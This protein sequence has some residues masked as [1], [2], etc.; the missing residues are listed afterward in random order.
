MPEKPLLLAA[1]DQR[2]GDAVHAR[3]PED[4]RQGTVRCTF[5]AAV[6]LLPE[7]GAVLL[8]VSA[9]DVAPALRLLEELPRHRWA[10]PVLI[11]EPEAGSPSERGVWVDSDTRV[12][13]SWPQD[14]GR[15]G[16]WLDGGFDP[17]GPAEAG[18]TVAQTVGR[19][20][21]SLTPSLVPLAEPIAVAAAHEVTVLLTGETGTGKTYLARF[22]HDHSPRKDHPFLTVPCGALPPN[23]IE[24]TF[25]GH[26]RGAFTG[27]DRPRE[28]K[29]AAAGQGTILLD[30][31]DTLAVE[32]QAGLLRVI[33]TGDYEP[34]GSNQTQHC[35]ARIIVASNWDLEEA[36][37][38]GR[39][40][41]D[42]FY[43]LNVLALHLPPL[44]ERVQDIAPLAR[45]LTARFNAKFNKDLVHLS[46]EALAV[47][48]SF[49]W[50]G[51]LRQL[52]NAL[53]QAVLMSS[54][55]QLLR[56][57]LPQVV[58]QA[59]PDR[60][61]APRPAPAPADLADGAGGASLAQDRKLRECALIRE[62]LERNGYRRSRT[63]KALGVSRVT[64]YNKMKK[65]GL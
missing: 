50:P 33:E 45:G 65:Y 28:G 18:E 60:G 44:R 53:Q 10:P 16:E 58:Q 64:L 46:P 59:R 17:T 55:P 12:R 19:L 32:H 57:H 27:A 63:A 62:A 24:S 3:L 40:R 31:I 11:L 54:G 56:Q 13:L 48:E 41:E 26:V 38:Q 61:V 21:G 36:V 23:L 29:F 5:E 20:L 35:H 30:E 43:R 8:A 34:V 15:L 25:F 22:I 6:P 52:E 1:H 37:A 42:L 51:N 7:A 2:L 49:P 39:F 47:L 4:R 9:D 14:A